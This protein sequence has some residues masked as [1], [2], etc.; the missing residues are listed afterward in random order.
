MSRS[1]W[2]VFLDDDDELL[3]HYVESLS[4][5][6]RE[7]EAD[8]VW[9][10]FE[11]RGGTDP[12]PHYR[13]R[14]FDPQNPH[15]VPITYMAR[16]AVLHEALATM[17]GFAADTGG[18]SWDV[19]DFPIMRAM[20]ETGARFYASDETVWRWHH[21]AANTSGLPTRWKR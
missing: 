10:W 14:Q 3:P 19:Q 13:G 9:G 20:F 16:T 2:T 11:V 18:G 6:A 5:F 15:I 17:G 21:H 1:E 4:A 7:H 12:F 8:V